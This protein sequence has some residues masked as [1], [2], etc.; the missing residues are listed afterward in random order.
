MSDFSN[1]QDLIQ[2]LCQS[3][4][5]SYTDAVKLVRE[6]V[7]FYQQTP[8]QYIRQRHRELQSTGLS[9]PQIFARLQQETAQRVFGSDNLS[10][11]QI[12]RMIYG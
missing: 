7:D 4:S 3:A 11:R 8:D 6:V 12:R 9:N 2:H 10:E 1:N 5:L